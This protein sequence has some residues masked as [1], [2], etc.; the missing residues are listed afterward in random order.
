LASAPEQSQHIEQSASVRPLRANNAL[1]NN[2]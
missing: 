2:V 1:S